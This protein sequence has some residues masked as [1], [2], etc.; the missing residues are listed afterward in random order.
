MHV[1]DIRRQGRRMEDR[2]SRLHGRVRLLSR[3]VGVR[4]AEVQSARGERSV[5]ADLQ[6]MV[7]GL[8]KKTTFVFKV[9]IRCYVDFVFSGHATLGDTDVSSGRPITAFCP[10]IPRS[11]L[12]ARY[13]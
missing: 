6:Q 5:E 8:F 11:N 1:V 9:K 12:S 10:K 3:Q 2:W 7:G 4:A 13:S